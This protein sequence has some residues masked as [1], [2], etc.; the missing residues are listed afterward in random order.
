MFSWNT[1]TASIFLCWF[2]VGSSRGRHV[3]QKGR[4]AV[5]SRARQTSALLHLLSS[6]ESLWRILLETQYKGSDLVLDYVHHKQMDIFPVTP[7]KKVGGEVVILIPSDVYQ[8]LLLSVDVLFGW[9]ESSAPT[10]QVLCVG[11]LVDAQVWL[12]K[13]G[14]IQFHKISSKAEMSSKFLCLPW[15]SKQFNMMNKIWGAINSGK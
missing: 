7:E 14:E 4:W 11:C 15:W 3:Y 10:C 2:G 5:E 13:S 9:N 6:A 12:L 8:K 1:S